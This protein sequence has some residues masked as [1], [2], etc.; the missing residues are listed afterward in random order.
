MS[1]LV[2]F[3]SNFG[4]TKIIADTVAA[5][6][7]AQATPLPSLGAVDLAGVDLLVIGSP[8]NAWK[9]T[10][11]MQAFLD[12][13]GEGALRGVSAAAFDT[14]VKL[15]IHGDA[16]GKISHAL[17]KAGAQIVAKPHGFTVEGRE[18]PLSAGEV[19]KARDWAR[20]IAV[21]VRESGP[22][23]TGVTD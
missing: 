21:A 19:E 23:S 4:N 6:L 7:G 12:G 15:F 17:E 14:R 16:A 3:D 2:L 18:G 8:I 9:P 10:A 1:T 11:K 22:G 20:S 13:L 5:E